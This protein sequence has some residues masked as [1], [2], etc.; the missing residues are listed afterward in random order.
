MEHS[1][2]L[3]ILYRFLKEYH[4][5]DEFIKS[6]SNK[7]LNMV[8]YHYC[9]YHDK[10][11]Y[12]M[13]RFCYKRNSEKL[14]HFSYNAQVNQNFNRII[15][16]ICKSHIINFINDNNLTNKLT[17]IINNLNINHIHVNNSILDYLYFL[18]EKGISPLQF[19]KH[20]ICFKYNQDSYIYWYNLDVKF[21]RYIKNV[22]HQ[23][24]KINEL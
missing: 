7:S 19:F 4:V 1:L 18:Y 15:L 16:S 21:M 17:E 11:I 24:I 12:Y 10:F 3:K 23:Q 6:I 20:L 2:L 14:K 13:Y 9:V 5:Y 8:V 22:L